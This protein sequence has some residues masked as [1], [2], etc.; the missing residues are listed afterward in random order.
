M[1]EAD[2]SFHDDEDV[3]EMRAHGVIG[4]RLPNGNGKKKLHIKKKGAIK[5]G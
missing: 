2:E 1:P 5:I 3:N 4:K